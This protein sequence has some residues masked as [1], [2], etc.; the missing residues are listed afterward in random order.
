MYKLSFVF[1]GQGSHYVGM[2]QGI[3]DEYKIVRETFE[4]ASDVAGFDVKKLCF[5]G[6]LSTLSHTKES[7]VSILTSGIAA[8]RVFMQEIGYVPQFCAGHSL[9]EY[10]ALTSAGVFKFSD[11]IKLVEFRAELAEQVTKETNGGMTIVE[12]YKALDLENE[13]KKAQ[14]NGKKVYISSYTTPN[15]TS[16]SGNVDDLMEIEE[17]ILKNGGQ[18]T[19]LIGSAPYHS[20]LMSKYA[21]ELKHRIESIE[22]GELRYPVISNVTGRPYKCINDTANN[23]SMH[24]TNPVQWVKTVDFFD[25]RGITLIIEMGPKN[26]ITNIIRNCNE[27]IKSIC[28]SNK[29]E[30]NEI[31]QL[32]KTN[33]MYSKHIPTL[34]TKCLVAG[35]ATPNKNWDNAAYQEGVVNPY[36]NIKNIQEKIESNESILNEDLEREALTCLKKIFETKMLPKSEQQEWFSQI[37]EESGEIYTF[38]DFLQ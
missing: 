10:L 8:F 21:E 12:N 34:I 30:R 38:K 17:I 1:P 37:L 33:E 3:Y 22:I 20:P 36:N 19:P 25:D 11:A 5:E 15:Q 7:H 4:E 27:N 26:L 16:I 9:G 31:F 13:C 18:I 29:S 28:L 23:L 14:E 32:Y 2:C 6:P 35:V 24:L